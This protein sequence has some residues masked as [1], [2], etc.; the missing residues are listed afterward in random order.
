M[1]KTKINSETSQLNTLIGHRLRQAR[2]YREQ[3]QEMAAR[4][5]AISR[6]QLQ[7]FESGAT[8]IPAVA[9]F[10]LAEYYGVEMSFLMQDLQ[11]TEQTKP[12]FEPKRII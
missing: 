1:T 4:G 8:H 3:S 7:R 5:L 9:L 10:K 2:N 11:E 12:H 6:Q